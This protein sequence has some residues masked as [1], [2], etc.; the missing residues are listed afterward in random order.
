MKK[1]A[2]RVITAVLA[3][4]MVIGMMAMTAFAADDTYSVVGSINGEDGWNKDTDLVKQADGTYSVDI[5]DVKAGSYEFKI[6][7]NH[8]W[9][10]GEYN[11]E[12]DAS[13]GGANAKVDVAKD[14]ST[15]TITFDGTKAAV[16]VKDA[17]ATTPAAPADKTPAAG[18]SSVMV[19]IV[20]AVAALSAVVAVVAKRRSVEA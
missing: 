8:A 6:R 12:G 17:S 1:I 20:A 18:D 19:Y 16:T 13:S 10:N 14:G 7:T 3:M 15:V 11:L 2:K 9:D 5:T 4:A